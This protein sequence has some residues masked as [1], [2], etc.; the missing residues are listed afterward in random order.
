MYN[1]EGNRFEPIDPELLKKF[2]GDV[3]VL[4]PT[5]KVQRDWTR[6]QEG[7]KVDLKGIS[8]KVDEVG[9]SRIVLKP[10]KRV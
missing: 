2:N 6:F 9:E 7:E 3:A 4:T 1:P 10:I 8:F 5:E